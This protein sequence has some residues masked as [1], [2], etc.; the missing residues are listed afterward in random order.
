MKGYD[1]E[2]ATTTTAI[3]VGCT[4]ATRGNA[5]DG[6]L[7]FR[8]RAK[9][10]I[11]R[12]GENIYPREVEEFPLHQSKIADL[13]CSGYRMRGWRNR[14]RLDLRSGETSAAQR[15][16]FGIGPELRRLWV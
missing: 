6:R 16:H 1:E 10:I 9:E 5:R 14:M 15:S 11:I 12:G 3:D 7:H 2:P 4:P 13:H 8:G